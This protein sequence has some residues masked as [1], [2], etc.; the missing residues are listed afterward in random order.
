MVVIVLV[1]VGMEWVVVGQVGGWIEY[2]YL[3][4]VLFYWEIEGNCIVVGID[5]VGF[6]VF[7]MV[8]EIVIL[9]VVVEGLVVVVQFVYQGDF[10]VFGWLWCIGGIY[11]YQ[12]EVCV[13]VG[14]GIIVWVEQWLYVDQCVGWLYYLFQG[15][16]DCVV[17]GFIQVVGQYYGDWCFGFGCFFWQCYI[18][19][20][21]VI[22]W[23][24]GI[25]YVFGFVWQLQ[26]WVIEEIVWQV[27][28]GFLFGGNCYVCGEV[29]VIGWCVIQVG[30]IGLQV[31]VFIWFQCFLCVVQVQF[32]VF[33][34]EFFDV[35]G[36]VLDCFFVGWVGVEFDLLVFGWCFGGDYLFEIDVVLVVWL[37]VGFVEGF[38]V[39][40]FQVQEYWLCFDWFV[41]VVVQ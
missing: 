13:V 39:G 31:Q 26:G 20:Q 35:Q 38:V 27:F 10:Q 36:Y 37:Q 3:V 7:E 15:V 24:C 32:Y 41:V 29:V 2:V 19:M 22:G 34:Q 30:I 23:Q 16:G 33:G 18:F 40:L 11:V 5:G 6:F 17:I 21:L 12:F 28:Y 4:F 1:L 14:I 25:D 8:G 9:V